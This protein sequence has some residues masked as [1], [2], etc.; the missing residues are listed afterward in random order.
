[1][2]P[3]TEVVIVQDCRN[4]SPADGLIGTYEGEFPFIVQNDDGTTTAFLNPR[5]LLP[6]GTHIWG[7]ECWWKPT[8]AQPKDINVAREQ[9]QRYKDLLK[10]IEDEE[11]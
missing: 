11:K 7:I 8:D 10:K 5:I 6:D 4:G 1:M 2:K 9:L 3:G